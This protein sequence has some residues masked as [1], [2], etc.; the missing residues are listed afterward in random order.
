MGTSRKRRRKDV[1]ER[2]GCGFLGMEGSQGGRQGPNGGWMI[3]GVD[4]KE[5]NERPS[6]GR[7]F[8]SEGDRQERE[9]DYSIRA[10]SAQGSIHASN[11]HDPNRSLMSAPLWCCG[12][13][14]RHT[15]NVILVNN[16]FIIFIFADRLLLSNSRRSK[17]TS[18]F[19]STLLQV[20]ALHLLQYSGNGFR[21][22]HT[23]TW[24]LWL[25]PFL[26]RKSKREKNMMHRPTRYGSHNTVYWEYCTYSGCHARLT[27]F[28]SPRNLHTYSTSHVHILTPHHIIII[29]NSTLRVMQCSQLLSSVDQ[30]KLAK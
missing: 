14:H 26:S 4:A 5:A 9:R 19:T 3:D 18:Q 21:Q 25:D 23:P 20:S 16:Q 11:V 6:V 15:V 22:T 29:T 8:G 28:P 12:P 30:F 2:T 24:G 13:C 27:K 1:K 10:S 7:S 17:P